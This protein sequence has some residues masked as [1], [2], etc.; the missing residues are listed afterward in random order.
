MSG[1][2]GTMDFE[3]GVKLANEISNCSMGLDF[4]I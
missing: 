3:E 2:S 1:R 4:R